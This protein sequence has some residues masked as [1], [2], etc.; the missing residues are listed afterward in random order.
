MVLECISTDRKTSVSIR[1]SK[2]KQTFDFDQPSREPSKGT[3]EINKVYDL[4][5]LQADIRLTIYV[6]S[7]KVHS[8][9]IDNRLESKGSKVVLGEQQ[10]YKYSKIENDRAREGKAILY[11]VKIRRKN[12]ELNDRWF[13]YPKSLLYAKESRNSGF[14]SVEGCMYMRGLLTA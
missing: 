2:I 5:D 7:I 3:T 8:K 1:N 11:G 4:D 9:Q 12:K 10:N 13:G 6:I 14:M